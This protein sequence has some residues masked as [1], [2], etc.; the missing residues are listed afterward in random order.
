M[1]SICARNSVHGFCAC[2]SAPVSLANAALAGEQVLRL[3]VRDMAV[4]LAAA[5]HLAHAPL[6]AVA[7]LDGLVLLRHVFQARA[8]NWLGC[9]QCPAP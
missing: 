6:R 1:A 9:A 2:G 7:H 5:R 3:E 4:C 8:L